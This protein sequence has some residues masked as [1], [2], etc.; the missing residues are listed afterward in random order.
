MAES[1]PRSRASIC[2]QDNAAIPN[3]VV[4]ALEKF[5][6]KRDGNVTTSDLLAGAHALEQLRGLNRFMKLTIGMLSVVV[7]ILLVGSFSSTMWAISLS[8]ETM[9]SG[10]VLVTPGGDA[11]RVMSNAFAVDESGLMVTRDQLDRSGKGAA[12]AT[13]RGAER[14]TSLRLVNGSMLLGAMAL[15]RA[16]ACRVHDRMAQ[17]VVD[18]VVVDWGGDGG[19]IHATTVMWEADGPCES[20]AV[21][22]MG[23]AGEWEWRAEC[24]ASTGANPP[25]CLVRYVTTS[26]NDFVDSDEEGHTTDGSGS[27]RKLDRRAWRPSDRDDCGLVDTLSDKAKKC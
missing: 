17:G 8:K 6:L 18:P 12:V 1:A 19:V 5:S 23:Q 22:M 24:G 20:S 26:P 11:V 13:A 15:D 2:Y 7:L 25:A 3:D 21:I 10:H 16:E 14:V 9:V 27:A 4:E